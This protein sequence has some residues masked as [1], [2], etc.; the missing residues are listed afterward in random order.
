MNV[1]DDGKNCYHSVSMLCASF[2][3]HFRRSPLTANQ[4]QNHIYKLVAS[5]FN[6]ILKRV[7]A[8]HVMF[9]FVASF[10][11][12]LQLL[13]RASVWSC[14]IAWFVTACSPSSLRTYVASSSSLDVKISAHRR[15]H[16]PTMAHS[17]YSWLFLQYFFC[18]AAD[19]HTHHAKPVI[20]A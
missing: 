3:S 20:A 13:H 2:I 10:Y 9:D 14:G 12:R 6:Y 18:F 16:L 5:S 8:F 7:T 11:A 19:T 17:N 1:K 15:Y 4:F